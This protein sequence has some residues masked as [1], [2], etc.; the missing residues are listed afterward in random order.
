MQEFV[1][2]QNGM[3]EG[4]K[5][6]K[7]FLGLEKV[8]AKNKTLNALMCED[9]TKTRDQRQILKEQAKFYLKLYSSN[10]QIT[11]ELHNETN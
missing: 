2:E 9:G 11:F 6:T 4:E 3:K 1:V 10:P 7:Y 5:S 8:K